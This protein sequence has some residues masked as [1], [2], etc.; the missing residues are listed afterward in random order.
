VG[1]SRC[2]ATK[3]GLSFYLFFNDCVCHLGHGDHRL[4]LWKIKGTMCEECPTIVGHFALEMCFFFGCIIHFRGK[5][6]E[7]V[8]VF[9]GHIGRNHETP[10]GFRSG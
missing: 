6:I 7:V 5:E 3:M 4:K 2:N 8:V 10:L 9:R 1:N